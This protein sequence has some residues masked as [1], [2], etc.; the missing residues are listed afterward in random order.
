MP[1]GV[2]MMIVVVFMAVEAYA[3]F[4]ITV[5]LLGERP[6]WRQY[7]LFYIVYSALE[8][9]LIIMLDM[10]EGKTWSEPPLWIQALEYIMTVFFLCM[11][12]RHGYRVSF[13]KVFG[14]VALGRFSEDIIYDFLT[15]AT[16]F[17]SPVFDGKYLYVMT[18][19]VLPYSLVAAFSLTAAFVLNKTAFS[20]Y[21]LC[22]FQGRVRSVGMMLAS[23]LLL[24]VNGMRSVLFPD[25]SVS[26]IYGLFCFSMVVAALFCIQFGAM[27]VASRDKVK[28][29][30]E[31]IA[32]QQA[33]M[34]L[35]EELQGEIRAFRH[36][37]TNLLSGMALSAQEGD[38]EA[39]QEF[40][41][42]T[43]GYFDEKLGSEIRQMEGLSNIQI[44]PVRS[45]I[46]TKLN[47][48]RQRH[49]QVTLEIMKPVTGVR[50]P[51][52][53]LL[54]CQGILLDNAIEAASEKEGK[55]HVILLQDV[56]ELFIAVANNYDV[57]PNLGALSKSGYTTKGKGHG[58]GLS[59]YRKMVSRCA[60]CVT[61][62][63]LK[64]DFLVQELRIPV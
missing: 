38:V 32:Q 47:L 5:A 60:D 17:Y 25:V 31:T 14:A 59:S 50:M 20:K 23:L 15:T 54:R 41:R 58:T 3:I 7:L 63:Y 45:L 28:A 21:F 44:Y 16:T 48:M 1:F 18:T 22:L 34:E 27:Y 37:F 49:I 51:I 11:T 55:I 4:R 40:M 35:L 62:T 56:G 29:Q 36:D 9:G 33:H 13:D 52:E 10:F 19:I 30:E 64:D 26:F 53:D 2:R 12:I 43:S 8:W 57:Q 6:R 42:R 61:R 46:S 39:I 24:T